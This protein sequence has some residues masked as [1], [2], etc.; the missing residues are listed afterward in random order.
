MESGNEQQKK[1]KKNER[2]EQR[3]SREKISICG[4]I[5]PRNVE[6]LLRLY[7]RDEKRE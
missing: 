7:H 4:A 3:K 1:R 6:E 5:E 2:E